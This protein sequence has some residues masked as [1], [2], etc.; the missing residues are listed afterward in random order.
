MVYGFFVFTAG[1]GNGWQQ[2]RPVHYVKLPTVV[3]V[4]QRQAAPQAIVASAA[5]NNVNLTR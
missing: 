5:V 1:P 3:V 4:G 2:P